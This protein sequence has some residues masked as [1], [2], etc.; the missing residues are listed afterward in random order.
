[1]DLRGLNHT[2]YCEPSQVKAS[3]K[4]LNVSIHS[5]WPPSP[6]SSTTKT[7][8]YDHLPTTT[9]NSIHRK[10]GYEHRMVHQS[11][12]LCHALITSLGGYN[13]EHGSQLPL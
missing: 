6:T 10:Q 2:S 13:K 5:A 9:K 7:Q 3:Q 11:H 12:R 4:E 8:C 1:M